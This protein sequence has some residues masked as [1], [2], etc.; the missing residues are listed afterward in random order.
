MRYPAHGAPVAPQNG[1]FF[2]FSGRFSDCGARISAMKRPQKIPLS[3]E[4][5]IFGVDSKMVIFVEKC[6]PTFFPQGYK[7]GR[8][9]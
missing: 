8:Q 6:S 1:P 5:V 2:G 9:R 3:I 4:P 7:W